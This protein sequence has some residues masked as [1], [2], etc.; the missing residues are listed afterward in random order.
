MRSNSSDFFKG[1]FLFNGIERTIELR[2]K[3]EA[4]QTRTWIPVLH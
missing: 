4:D 2:K 3:K 1:V